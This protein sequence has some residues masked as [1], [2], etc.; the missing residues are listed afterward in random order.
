VKEEGRKLDKLGNRDQEI[1]FFSTG[2]S[3]DW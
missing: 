2:H 3:Q 1:K